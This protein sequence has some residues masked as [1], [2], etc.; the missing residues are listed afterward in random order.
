[1]VAAVLRSFRA[2]AVARP[3]FRPLVQARALSISLPRQA[4]HSAP[5]LLGE[6]VKPGQVPTDEQ[7]A[8]GLERFELLGKLEG[9]DVF[10]MKPLEVT[11]LGTVDDPIAVYSLFPERHVG[12]TGFPADSHDT[13]W[14]HVTKELK[15]HRCPE[16]GSVYTLNFQGDEHADHHH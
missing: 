8:T 2:A 3:A 10:D 6:G 7:Q 11:R 15:N 16:C 4:G 5:Q 13:V 12:C 1:M 14:L 9:V